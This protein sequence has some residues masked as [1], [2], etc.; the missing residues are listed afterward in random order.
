MEHILI[1]CLEAPVNTIWQMARNFWPHSPNLWP[2]LDIG[3]LLGCGSIHLPP[4]PT[5][6]ENQPELP[7]QRRRNHRGASRLLQILLSE[8]LHLIWVL[9]CE[10]VIQEKTHSTNEIQ[11]RWLRAINARLTDD[12]VIATKVK[13]DKSFPTLAKA[14]WKP[15][16]AVNG[17]TPNNWPHTS[18]V[19]SG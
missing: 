11:N 12:R 14:T 18:E 9:R 4:E 3:T 8:S 6:H 16:L 7:P 1:H 5:Q 13:R 2:H 10:R 15:A 19:F 17:K